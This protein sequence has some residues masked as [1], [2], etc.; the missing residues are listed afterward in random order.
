[1]KDFNR[2]TLNT[3]QKQ[4]LDQ[5]DRESFLTFEN[6]FTVLLDKYNPTRKKNVRTD[7]K[8]IFLREWEKPWWG[9]QSCFQ[10]FYLVLQMK[11]IRAYK[12]QKN[13]AVNSATKK[14]KIL[15]QFRLTKYHWQWQVLENSQPFF[16]KQNNVLSKDFHPRGRWNNMQ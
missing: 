9:D 15:Y 10:D 13:S 5:V 3:E 4:K 7:D 14:T 1:M 8:S 2:L 6:V 12:K 11:T 16:S